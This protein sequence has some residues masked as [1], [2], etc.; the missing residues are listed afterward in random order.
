MPRIDGALMPDLDYRALSNA[1]IWMVGRLQTDA[2]RKRVVEAMSSDGGL[3]DMEPE[4]LSATLKLL[5][6]R[7]FVMRNVHRS[8]S[9]ALLK[10]RTTL[11]RRKRKPM[12]L[13]N[14]SVTNGSARSA[15][16][17]A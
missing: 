5:S 4:E 11:E 15:H 9:L 10:S 13:P 6:P 3:E 17:A 8:P 12:C 7:W 14:L 16:G 2:D 1:G